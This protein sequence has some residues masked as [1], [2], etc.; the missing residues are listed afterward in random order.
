[1][2]KWNINEIKPINN[3]DIAGYFFSFTNSATC[4]F[5]SVEAI[6]KCEGF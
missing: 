4:K 1:M 2:S 5:N 6:E 3:V